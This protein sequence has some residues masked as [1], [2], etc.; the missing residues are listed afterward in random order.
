M[1]TGGSAEAS[2]ADLIHR[3]GEP[4]FWFH[5]RPRAAARAIGLI[6]ALPV[7]DYESGAELNSRTASQAMRTELHRPK[8]GVLT[9]L[10]Q[11]V[12]AR[13]LDDDSDGPNRTSRKK[14]RR[15]ERDGV[16][17]SRVDCPDQR[18]DLLQRALAY[19]ASHPD[20]RYRTRRP[21]LSRLASTDLWFVA[22]DADGEPA[23]LAVLAIDGPS[24]ML[25][26]LRS[27]SSSEGASNARYLMSEVMATQASSL[28]AT[29][30]FITG[31]P[32]NLPAGLL[33][34]SRSVGFRIFR[35]RVT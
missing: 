6:R 10:Q 28:G 2:L 13:R 7:L 19:E 25:L 5:R 9:P 20:E 24:A 29:Q 26:Y 27:L 33:H 11:A 34:F 1:S 14:A 35:V 4:S 16:Q 32:L 15:A 22:L 30:L 18:D 3:H 21:D 17:W 12:L 8:L 31:N 23:V